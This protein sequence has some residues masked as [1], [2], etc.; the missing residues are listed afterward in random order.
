[1]KRVP[2]E[3]LVALIVGFGLGLLYAWVIAP[4]RYVDTSPDTLRAD[5][6]DQF[7]SAIAGAYAATGNLDRAR[8]RLALLKDA[9]PAQ[10]LTA[11]AQRM[12]AQ[13]ETFDLVQ[14]VASLAADLQSGAASARPS[15]TPTTGQVSQS[16][17]QTINP[18]PQTAEATPTAESI[19]PTATSTPQTFDT[20]TPRPTHTPLPTAGPPFQLVD[21]SEVCNTNLTDGLM[22]V[23]ILDARGHQMPGVEI[24]LTW[25]GG[26][27]HFFTGLKPEIAN[28]YADYVMQ[29][30]IVYTL[31]VG[32][33]G[34]PV[35][36]L[37]APAC[38]DANGE[39]YT[40]GLKL[41]FKQP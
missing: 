37:S 15:M 38:P 30:G 36:N 39:T 23:S 19:S 28:G 22:Q 6:K 3:W 40:G 10:E 9:N 21:Q 8:A 7:R 11:Q 2:W 29:P 14:Q 32:E 24:I 27:E 13:G 31:R 26:E 17:T 25:S 12:L 35:S 4:T 33:T 16:I 34:V 5:F 1:M 41:T 18:P 20:A